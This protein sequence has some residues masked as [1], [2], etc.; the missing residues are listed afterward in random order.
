MPKNQASLPGDVKTLRDLILWGEQQFSDAQLAFGHGTDNA[1]DEAAYLVSHAA[2]LPPDFSDEHLDKPLT[3]AQREAASALLQRRIS[4]CKPVAYLTHEAWFAGLQFYVDERVLIPRS[5]IAELIEERFSPWIAENKVKRILDMG[6]GSGCIAIACAAAFPDA[7][8]DACDISAQALEVAK[9][10]VERHHLQQRVN[11]IESDLFV[12][13]PTQ[14]YDIIVSNP[15]YVDA[16][17]MAGLPTEYH[18]EPAGGLA[19]GEH[20]LDFVLPILCAANDYLSAHGIL[21]VEVG[22]SAQA[23]A[24]R[25]PQVPFVWLEFARGGEG[26]FLLDAKQ[27]SDYHES[28]VNSQ[29]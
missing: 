25:L 26:V 6:T 9:V 28:I 14:R 22:N 18:H 24:E 19:A 4:E 27:I 11:L 21:I 3:I 15:P 29:F 8:V 12:A 2:G 10:N 7:Q 16:V 13:L 1:L 5:P 20:G 17:D 23:L